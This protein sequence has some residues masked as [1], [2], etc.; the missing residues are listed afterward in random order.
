[1]VDERQPR[2]EDSQTIFILKAVDRKWTHSAE[3][4]VSLPN[5]EAPQTEIRDERMNRS[6]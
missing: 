5:S 4:T 2:G 6:A 1:M 3:Q